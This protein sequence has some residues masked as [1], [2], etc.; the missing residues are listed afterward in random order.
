MSQGEDKTYISVERNKIELFE[1]GISTAYIER[2][3]VKYPW[4][5]KN[6]FFYALE[7]NFIIGNEKFYYDDYEYSTTTFWYYFFGEVRN[8]SIVDKNN[9]ILCK[10]EISKPEQYIFWGSFAT[11]S[12]IYFP[13]GRFYDISGGQ[14]SIIQFKIPFISFPIKYKIYKISNSEKINTDSSLSKKEITELMF[15]GFYDQWT[16]RKKTEII[17][18]LVLIL[19]VIS[20]YFFSHI[21]L[22]SIH[23]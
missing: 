15:F 5:I 12:R 19:S 9:K 22:L 2:K 11:A 14:K 7:E 17:I 21:D 23:F 8:H 4:S 16:Y 3:W 20:V 10:T 18:Y 1:N 6:L 13:D